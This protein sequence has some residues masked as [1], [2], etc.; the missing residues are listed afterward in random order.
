MD[1]DGFTVVTRK[2]K[3]GRKARQKKSTRNPDSQREQW[4]STAS[5]GKK[6]RAHGF[7]YV[8]RQP[9]SADP[10]TDE[11]SLLTSAKRKFERCMS[12]VQRSPLFKQLCLVLSQRIADLP[13]TSVHFTV[14]GLGKFLDNSSGCFQLALAYLMFQYVQELTATQPQHIANEPTDTEDSQQEPA[15]SAENKPAKMHVKMFFY[16]P[17]T[18]AAEVEYLQNELGVAVLA[19]GNDEGRRRLNEMAGRHRL[20]QVLT[21]KS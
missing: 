4:T 3:R 12:M 14:Y 1:A 10:R 7:K 6:N 8:Q 17:L 20:K 11:A 15:T 18:T 19:E 5:K 13:T 16:D 21:N 9:K 2:P